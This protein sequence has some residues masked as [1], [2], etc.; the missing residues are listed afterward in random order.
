MDR[1]FHK[2]PGGALSVVALPTEGV[3][4]NYGR[5]AITGNLIVVALPTEGVDRNTA[6]VARRGSTSPHPDTLRPGNAA[7]RVNRPAGWGHPALQGDKKSLCGI[8]PD[9][10]PSSGAF[11]ATFPQGGR[12]F[13]AANFQQPSGQ[14][15]LAGKPPGRVG[16]PRPTLHYLKTCPQADTPNLNS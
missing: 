15:S 16:S 4:R 1:N 12:L 7:W 3:D 9:V 8:Q 14:R 6:R 10:F 5:N 13:R 11:R 2:L